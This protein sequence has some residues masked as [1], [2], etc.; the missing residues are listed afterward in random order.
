[1]ESD[2]PSLKKGTLKREV[3][4][5]ETRR[6]FTMN[7]YRAHLEERELFLEEIRAHEI[8]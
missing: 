6:D 4:F 2:E 3:V 1:M 8:R 7:N 5:G